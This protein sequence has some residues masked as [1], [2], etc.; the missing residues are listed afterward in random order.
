MPVP[1]LASENDAI[2][3]HAQRLCMCLELISIHRAT[4]E[5]PSRVE[6]LE[7]ES[8]FKLDLVRPQCV[9]DLMLLAIN[10]RRSCVGKVR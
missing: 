8:F 5:A 7:L 4:L 1:S 9:V 2:G 10:L 6:L 3:S